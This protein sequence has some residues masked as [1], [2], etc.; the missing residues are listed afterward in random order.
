MLQWARMRAGVHVTHPPAGSEARQ[1]Q[2]EP[3]RPSLDGPGAGEP[4]NTGRDPA[5]RE[6]SESSEGRHWSD[7]LSV[8]NLTDHHAGPGAEA[9]ER[10]FMDRVADPTSGGV[11]DMH[12]ARV[13]HRP[14]QWRTVGM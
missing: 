2:R 1:S 11:L 12:P 10:D 14:A 13:S 5:S 8:R 7:R 9:G 6:P 3:C 4:H